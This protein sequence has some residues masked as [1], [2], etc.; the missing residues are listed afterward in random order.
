MSLSSSLWDGSKLLKIHQRKN[1][2][3]DD[4]QMVLPHSLNFLVALITLGNSHH[5]INGGK[6]GCRGQGSESMILLCIL[7]DYGGKSL[8]VLYQH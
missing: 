4:S 5:E 1:K 6:S 2:K 7:S 8:M 3:V